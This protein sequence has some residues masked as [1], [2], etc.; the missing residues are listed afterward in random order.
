MKSEPLK[1]VGEWKPLGS[2]TRK[3]VLLTAAAMTL[4]GCSLF[5]PRIEVRPEATET[6]VAIC[7]S[8]RDSIFERSRQDT[9]YTQDKLGEMYEIY[10]AACPEFPLPF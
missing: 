7:E 2:V 3:L 6:E 10:D 8:W 5:Q 1:S 4:T 9:E